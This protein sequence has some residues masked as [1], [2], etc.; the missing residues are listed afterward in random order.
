MI[1]KKQPMKVDYFLI[2]IVIILGIIS[3]FTLYTIQ[4]F[5]PPSIVGTKFY[6]R[7]SIWY[8]VGA[9]VIAV[10]MLVDYEHLR[11][12]SW[13]LYSIGI[14]LLAGLF[15]LP[16]PIVLTLNNATSWYSIPGL[17]LTFQPGE[18]MKLLYIITI[19][20]VITAHNE[21]RKK[22]LFRD[23]IWLIVK[24]SLIALPPILLVAI[25]PD[26]GTALVLSA[27]TAFLILVSGIR[28]SIL[29]TI[30][31]VFIIIIASLISLYFFFPSFVE[32]QLGGTIFNHVFE[33]FEAWME[34]ESHSD[35]AGMQILK[36]M[37]SIG[38][39]QLVGKGFMNIQVYIPERHTD[40]IFSAIAEQFGF[41][42]A[43]LL[44]TI[45]FLLIYRMIHI[46]L[47]CKNPFGSYLCTG[48]IGMFTYQIIQNIGM[49]LQLL[50]ITGLPLPFISYGGTSLLAYL[51]GVGI[52]LNVRLRTHISMFD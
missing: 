43:S 38:S 8:V 44:I 41:V 15:I 28:W 40:M 27:I 18:F 50:P 7:Q 19:S 49:S 3:C 34:P 14:L 1:D 4:P 12:L 45:F 24:I 11:R 39:G 10:F 46:A 30:F 16:A 42:G 6:L 9:T 13:V 31:S 35:T 32:N 52:V 17:N 47:E 37:L 29:I 25:Q 48:V 2:C 21:K 36:A 51:V 22:R 33:R 26:L 5:L 20:H 23:D